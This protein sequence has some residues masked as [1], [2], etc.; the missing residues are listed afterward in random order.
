MAFLTTPYK[1]SHINGYRRFSS[2]S[3]SYLPR[4]IRR[5]FANTLNA[6]SH[7]ITTFKPHHK[8]CEICTFFLRPYLPQ[9]Q[10]SGERRISDVKIP[11]EG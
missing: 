11:P 3:Q 7:V 4:K 5:M 8:V 10:E 2:I 6:E 1:R 9:N